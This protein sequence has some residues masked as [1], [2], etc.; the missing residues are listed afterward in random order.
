MAR[1]GI[2]IVCPEAELSCMERLN[3]L[4]AALPRHTVT[5]SRHYL[6]TADLPVRYVIVVVPPKQ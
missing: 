6:G 4:A 3:A 2:A 1:D 5:L